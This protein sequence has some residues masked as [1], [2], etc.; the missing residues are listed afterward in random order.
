MRKFQYGVKVGHNYLN[1]G[2]SKCAG[3]DQMIARSNDFSLD[4]AFRIE[5]SLR[6]TTEEVN[7]NSRQKYEADM[8]LR[9]A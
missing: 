1:I 5:F 4:L 6:E 7:A 9:K 3:P 2:L 8:T